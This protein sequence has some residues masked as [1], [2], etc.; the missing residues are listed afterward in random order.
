[1]A[2]WL[3]IEGIGASESS[4]EEY[5]RNRGVFESTA[6][7]MKLNP[8]K[9]IT[10]TERCGRTMVMGKGGKNKTPVWRC[11][12]NYCNSVVQ[13]ELRITSSCTTNRNEESFKFDSLH[14]Q[15]LISFSS[16]CIIMILLGNL[17]F[18]CEHPSQRY[19]NVTTHVEL[20]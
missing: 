4:A 19:L 7:C 14:A 9:L 16:G 11:T 12:R 1:M 3:F 17:E 5:L 10:K 8:G 6:V 20:G 15:D 2:Q 18:Y 13:Y